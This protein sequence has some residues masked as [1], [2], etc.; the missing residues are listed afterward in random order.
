VITE[1]GFQDGFK[2]AD[3]LGTEL[4]AEENYFEGEGGQ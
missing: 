2:L 4:G 3:S 1:H